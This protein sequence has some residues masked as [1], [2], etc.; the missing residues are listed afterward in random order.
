MA[1]RELIP[2]GSVDNAPIG[3]AYVQDNVLKNGTLKRVSKSSQQLDEY[4][5]NLH[6]HIQNHKKLESINLKSFMNLPGSCFQLLI[7]Y[8]DRN[9]SIYYASSHLLRKKKT[10]S[11]HALNAELSLGGG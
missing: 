3:L 11:W 2:D 9:V 1:N 10:P 5:Q 4:K 7:G 6:Q 8:G